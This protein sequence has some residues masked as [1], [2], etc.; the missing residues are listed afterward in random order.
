VEIDAESPLFGWVLSPAASTLYLDLL[1]NGHRPSQ[2]LIAGGLADVVAELERLGFVRTSIGLERHVIALPPEVPLVRNYAARA[3]DWIQRAPDPSLV[4]R[5][6]RAISAIAG[7]RV[8]LP[9]I[10][11]AAASNSQVRE[12][13]TRSERGLVASSLFTSARSELLVMQ[14]AN[15]NV[16]A[17]PMNIEVAPAD[18]L[19]RGVSMRFLYD[20]SVLEDAE[21][22]AAALDEVATGA[23]A[24]VTAELAS[25]FV[26]ADRR[27]A[28]VKTSFAPPNAIYT[29]SVPMISMM[30]GLFEA[31]WRHASPIGLASWSD[32]TTKLSDDH[33]R[34]LALV[35]NGM[36]NEAIARTLKVNPRTVRRRIDDLSEMYGVTSRNA[37]I[38]AAAKGSPA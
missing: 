2:D 28:M 14:S 21:F 32:S 36:N 17:E 30:I 1:Q 22:L 12:L 35:I 10:A 38:A 7:T 31:T 20:T 26:V 24:R 15:V 37:L 16:P 11:N 19:A 9:D 13:P 18:L 23:D 8:S 33:Q 29:E 3:T 6:L 4:E 25:D 5:D 27:C 34:I